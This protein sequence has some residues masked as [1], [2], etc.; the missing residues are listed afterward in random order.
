MIVQIMMVRV[1][2]MTLASL[3]ERVDMH[4]HRAEVQHDLDHEVPHLGTS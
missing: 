1:G 4:H 2:V 3:R